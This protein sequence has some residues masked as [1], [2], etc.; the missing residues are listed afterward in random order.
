MNQHTERHTNSTKTV[1]RNAKLRHTQMRTIKLPMAKTESTNSR[2]IRQEKAE[3]RKLKRERQTS[4][5]ECLRLREQDSKSVRTFRDRNKCR[6][7]SKISHF[8]I[9]FRFLYFS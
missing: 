4:E 7:N 9:D 5:R 1:H 2:L 8:Q 6:K 3:M